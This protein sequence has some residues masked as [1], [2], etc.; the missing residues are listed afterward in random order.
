MIDHIPNSAHRAIEI[1]NQSQPYNINRDTHGSRPWHSY[2][3]KKP[4]KN[5]LRKQI[6]AQFQSIHQFIDFIGCII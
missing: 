3:A 4:A 1:L 5:N 6:V 2:K